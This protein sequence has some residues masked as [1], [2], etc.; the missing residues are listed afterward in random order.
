VAMSPEPARAVHPAVVRFEGFEIDLESGVLSRNGQQNR[1][2]GQPLQLLELLLQQPGRIAT[3]EQIQ[4]HLWPDG[5]VVEFEHSVNAAVKRLREALGDD[6]DKPTFV[7]TI[8]RR[9]Y[10]FI[11][12]V[13]SGALSSPSVPTQ[14]HAAPIL[15]SASTAELWNKRRV[16]V[17]ASVA[18][19]LIVAA[20]ATWRVVFAR[21]ALTGTDV[22]LLA[23]FVNKTGDPVF[24]NSLD[25]A[26]EVKLTESPFLSLFPEA[27]ARSTMRT[28]RHDPN[29]RVTQELGIEI[30]KRQ[31][32]KA[33]VVPEI[34]A[35]GG[36][37]L[38]TLEAID[39]RNQKS[40]ALT[41]AEAESKDKVI[42]A[43]GKAGSQLRRRLGESLSSLEK[44]D[45]PLD[46]A[47]TSSLEA[48][49]AYRTGQTLYRSGR[50]RESI[51]FFERAVELDPQL[52][53]AYSMLGSAYYNTGDQQAS[54]KNFAKAFNL[55]DGRLT[56]EEN[57]QTTAFYHSAITGNLEKETAVLVLYKQA[58]PRSAFAHSM[59]GRDYG[60]QGRIE[61]ALQEFHWAMDD[62]PIPSVSLSSNASHTLMILGRFD[63]AKKLL[64]QW[65][66]KGPLLA[67]PA[68][69]RY[70]LAFFENDS[71]AMGRLARETPGDDARWL[72]FQMRF[73]FLHGDFGKLRSLSETL[74]KQ[75]TGAKRMENVADELAWHAWA[76][77]FVGNYD[78]A[79]K[80]C[81]Q[82]RQ[83]SED[84][85][86]ALDY[87]AKALG[88][89][90]EAMQAE[91]LAAKKDRLYPEDTRNL[92]MCLPEMRSI[93][94]RKRGNAVMAVELLA[95]VVPY[96]Q[97]TVSILYYRATAYLAARESRK[98]AAEFEKIIGYRGWDEW[99]IFTPLAQ[100]GLARAYAMQGDRQNSRKAYDDFFT[101]WKDADPDIPI[102]R[103]AKTEY[104]RLT[105]TTS[106]GVLGFRD[107]DGGCTLSLGSA[108]AS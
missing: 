33:V 60:L 94:E 105:A 30:C 95:P 23:S 58:Y 15:P 77:S 67:N 45:A 5:T 47:T 69:M 87:C 9:G 28:M 92:K 56:Q 39:A 103:Q 78:L 29:E 13:E 49:Q 43:L 8:P 7:E 42:A 75:Q 26:L 72:S 48:L 101:T 50:Q 4:Q 52:C 66:Q 21:P 96:E 44:Y 24:D 106:A 36:R 102:L 89:A 51:A 80:L 37:Y 27:D 81:R 76:E 35:F 82:A 3:R 104:K 57:F 88:E 55:K 64:D 99:E 97:G 6:A 40:I 59:L 17:T 71:A 62:S 54:R 79:R 46:L 93:I 98:A 85:P 32:L 14:E 2:Q 61:D 91:M 68:A 90:G 107:S 25:R 41:E 38:V 84:S 19:F 73:A 10:R 34:A 108:F 31:G 11:A 74:V 18:V 70:Q 12:Q 53:S 20:L 100:L 83:A 1:L 22:I 65:W 63:E 16:A 86:N